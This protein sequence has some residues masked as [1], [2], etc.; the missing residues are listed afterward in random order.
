MVIR[1]VKWDAESIVIIV[2][3]CMNPLNVCLFIYWPIKSAVIKKEVLFLL[4]EKQFYR[5]TVTVCL[6]KL[7]SS[8]RAIKP[9]IRAIAE[10]QGQSIRAI[11]KRYGVASFWST[12]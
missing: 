11:L 1:Y 3:E 5:E 2:F 6:A 8:N 12:A 4:D 9:K 7:I 10:M